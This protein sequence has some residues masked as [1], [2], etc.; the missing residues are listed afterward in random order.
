M[1]WDKKDKF[2]KWKSD[3]GDNSE[4]LVKK[5]NKLPEHLVNE[6]QNKTSTG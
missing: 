1:Q 6:L 2:W 4:M 3:V 5:K